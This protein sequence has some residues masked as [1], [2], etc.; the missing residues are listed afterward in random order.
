MSL[1]PFITSIIARIYIKEPINWIIFSP[2]AVFNTL[3]TYLIVYSASALSGREL[4][5][6]CCM[7][8][9]VIAMSLW[10]LIQQQYHL[11]PFISCMYGQVLS[12]VTAFIIIIIHPFQHPVDLFKMTQH[13]WI[14]TALNAFT[15]AAGYR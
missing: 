6:Y 4:A 3:G 9:S 15:G 11:D 5:G 2:C 14:Y 10:T 8:L 13:H 7:F 1:T 12:S